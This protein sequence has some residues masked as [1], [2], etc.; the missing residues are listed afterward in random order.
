MHLG[1]YLNA[2][3]GKR[4]PLDIEKIVPF[5]TDKKRKVELMTAEE[6]EA[7]KNLKVKWQNR[8]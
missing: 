7:R 4:G 2:H 6:Y 5:V 3:R 8:N 1:A